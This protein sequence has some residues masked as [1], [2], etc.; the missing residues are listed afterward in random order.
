[1]KAW[2]TLL[3]IIRGV[4][5]CDVLGAE[6]VLRSGEGDVD[7]SEGGVGGGEK[8]GCH[9]Q[10]RQ[11]R[12]AD[13]DGIKMGDQARFPRRRAHPKHTFCKRHKT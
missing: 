11:Q 13:G 1:M 5:S 9:V 3:S 6:R 10:R 12:W 7:D 8:G 2:K 4:V